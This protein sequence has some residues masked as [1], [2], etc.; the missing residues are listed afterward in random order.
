MNKRV[1]ETASRLGIG[2]FELFARAKVS[3]GQ[4]GDN[5]RP[6][7]NRYLAIGEVP[8]FVDCFIQQKESQDAHKKYL[9]DRNRALRVVNGGVG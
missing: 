9:S 5:V 6:A 7:Y 3:Y 4:C 8:R 1:E 2:V